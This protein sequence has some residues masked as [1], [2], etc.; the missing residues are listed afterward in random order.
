M[1]RAVLALMTIVAASAALAQTKPSENYVIDI[2]GVAHELALGQEKR[3]KLKS[4]AEIPLTL[5]KKAFSQFV[6]G[7]LSFE[8]PDSFAVASTSVDEET[9]Q[10]IGISA[11]GTMLLVQSYDQ[12]DPA[13]LL[14]VMYDKLLE[15]QIAMG[16]PIEKSPLSRTLSDGAKLTG[17]TAHY[18]FTDD[19]VTLDIAA[20]TL[21]TG[22][23]L[24]VT[25]HDILSAPEE[26]KVVDRFWQSLSLGNPVIKP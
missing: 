20:R 17:V 18:K 2:E 9:T 13:S 21:D 22:G 23:Y 6:S 10:Y 5:R 14:E 24:V 7:N 19:E 15:E 1:R 25:M 8:H 3:I 12:T 26:K 11:N 16:T 4:G